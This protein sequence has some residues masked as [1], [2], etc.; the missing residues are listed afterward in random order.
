MILQALNDLYARLADD[1]TYEIAP[2]GFSPQKISFRIRIRPDGSLVQIEDARIKSDRGRAIPDRQEVPA[3]EKRTSGVKS[4]F[5]CDKPEY[6]LGW[7]SV[8]EKQNAAKECFEAFKTTHLAKEAEIMDLG[9][10]SVCRFLE[11]WQ[12]EQQSPEVANELAKLSEIGTNF[13]IWV[14]Q[15]EKVGIHEH[16]PV[17]SW[18]IS[19]QNSKD[20]SEA[21]QC[22]VTGAVSSICRIHPDIKGFKSSVALV[23]IQENSSYESYGLSKTENCPVSESAAF[24]YATALNALTD[25]PMRN[26]HRTR[27]ADTTVVHWT[28]EKT[29]FESVFAEVFEEPSSSRTESQDQN[30]LDQISRL[31]AAIKSGGKYQEFGDPETPFF[32]LG[33]EQPN[34]GRFSIRF[35]H[36]STIS[37][38][39]GKLHDHH[40]CLEIVRQF[41]DQTGKGFPDPEFP[42]IWRILDQTP[43]PKGGKPDRDKIPPLLG[44]AYARAIIEGGLYPEGLFA[45]IIRRI[46]ADHTIN[47]LRAAAIKA[48]LVRNHNQTITVMLD[49]TNPDSAYRHG[50]LFAVLEKIQEEGHYAQTQRKL[51]HTIKEKY[52]SS[53]C[54]TPAAVFPRL[55]TL[56][57][58]HQRHLNPGR[59]IQFEQMVGDIKWD[60]SG[61]KK[62]HTLIEQGRFILGYYHQ[63][64][65]LF[66]S[67]STTEQLEP[68]TTTV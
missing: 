61:T 39:I 27:I 45:A 54:A 32:I 55:E 3:H 63:R 37:D 29:I 42:A 38:L 41:N 17:R 34:P 5:L 68:E 15:E 7:T 56:S 58:H 31:L 13:G 64:R 57:V 4:Q 50:R 65:S 33:L 1:P 28:K 26:R 62:T 48:V 40:R 46:H 9:Y 11:K 6:M 19:H 2:P 35:F 66:T 14:L 24:R 16:P 47:Y 22:L 10:S 43:P 36:R 12:T 8:P 20:P 49:P 52:F 67:N 23:G 53:A 60:L 25:G 51:E 44:G 18:W 59:R 30:R 21:S